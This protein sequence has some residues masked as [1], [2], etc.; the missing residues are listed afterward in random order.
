MV[1]QN[2][3]W[4]CID[5]VNSPIAWHCRLPAYIAADGGRQSAPDVLEQLLA[6]TST[7]PCEERGS[8]FCLEVACESAALTFL[9]FCRGI[10]TSLTSHPALYYYT[11]SILYLNR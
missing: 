11:T 3:E 7:I 10:L 9:Y 5:P 8:G 6:E 1:A 4:V 2:V